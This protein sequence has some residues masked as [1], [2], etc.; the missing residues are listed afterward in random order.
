MSHKV[1][2]ALEIL[3]RYTLVF[4]ANADTQG[5]PPKVTEEGEEL[6]DA[7]HEALRSQLSIPENRVH[8]TNGSPEAEATL[9]HAQSPHTP[10][11]I[12][13]ELVL[14]EGA[15][16]T[17]ATEGEKEWTGTAV[18]ALAEAL[19]QNPPEPGAKRSA[20][21]YCDQLAAR[22]ILL[23]MRRYQNLMDGQP[24]EDSNTR[25]L[26]QDPIPPGHFIVTNKDGDLIESYHQ[27]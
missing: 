20:Q 16:N 26:D 3:L 1:Q 25:F 21:I 19:R 2:E 22:T 13:S 24:L 15:A 14:P 23:A 18:L 7:A 8:I 17:K 5:H 4:Q 12:L 27:E 9:F 6:I 11:V 10:Y